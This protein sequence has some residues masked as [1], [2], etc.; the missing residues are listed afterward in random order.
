MVA[1]LDGDFIKK[2]WLKTYTR[3]VSYLFY[4][5][6]PLTTKGRWINPLVFALFKLQE[7]I[8]VGKKVISPIFILG[9]G[10]SGTTILGVTLGMHRDVGFLNE[11]KAYWAHLNDKDD[12]IGS[13][14]N[15]TGCYCLDDKEVDDSLTRKAHA[16]Y[17]NYLRF[18]FSN[19]IVDKYPEMVFRYS[20]L[21]KIFPDAKYLF[22]YRNGWDTCH[23]I[24]LW[25][26][27]LGV[28]QADEKHDWWGLN[29]QKWF[30]LCDQVVKSDRVLGKYHR[31]IRSYNNHVNRAAVEWIV[32][33]KCGLAL[34]KHTNVMPVKYEDFVANPSFRKRVIEF[35]GL[36]DDSKFASYSDKVLCPVKPKPTFDMPEEIS[37][38]FKRVMQQLG[39]E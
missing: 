24:E 27:R 36:C 35:C 33:M 26:K 38:E 21:N 18:T 25:S 39:Y 34:E 7:Y 2:S 32:T 17:G 9:T 16:I 23:S 30:A 1:Q 13:Y 12:L 11:P 15:Q 31:K 10:R 4:E 8:P 5:G 6:R 3:L 20:Y 14:Q 37:E 28:T 29:D 22:L 19:R